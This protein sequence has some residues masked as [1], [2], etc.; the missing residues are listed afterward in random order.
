[1]RFRIEPVV[2]PPERWLVFSE[3]IIQDLPETEG[4][5]VL[6]DEQKE[7]YQ[8]TGVEN[9][10]QEL[11]EEYEKGTVPKYF[12]Y[13][14]DQMFTGKERQLIQQYMKKHG[15]M[16]TGNDELDDLF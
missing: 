6:Y 10:R 11:M 3:E 15:K 8:I 13:E 4:V 12:S 5:Y 9:I 7:I 2:L 16:P 14:E 1:M